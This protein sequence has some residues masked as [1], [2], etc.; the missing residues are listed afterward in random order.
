V[1]PETKRPEPRVSI[2]VPVLDEKVHADRRPVPARLS[3]NFGLPAA[4]AAGLDRAG[5]DLEVVVD[6]DLR[7]WL[8]DCPASDAP[9]D[10]PG[11]T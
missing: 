8:G 4:M 11:H 1:S 10:D 5:V 2:V 7:R 9:A 3:R 6:A